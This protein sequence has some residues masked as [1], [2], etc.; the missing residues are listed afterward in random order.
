MNNIKLLHIKCC[1]FQFFNSPVALKNQ[2]KFWP[3]KKKLKWRPCHI[4][5]GRHPIISTLMLHMP[6]P[7]QS[8]SPHHAPRLLSQ[9]QKT[10]NPHWA[11]YPSATLR[12]SISPSSILSSP[13]FADSLPS[14][15]RFQS[16]M[17]THSGHK[18]C[19]SFPLCSMNPSLWPSGIG[20]RFRRNRLWVRFLAVSDI[21]PMFIEPTITWVPSGFLGTYGLTQ[22]LC[23]K[24][25]IMHPELSG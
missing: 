3:P 18:P 11:S 10:T 14:S 4:P 21:Y 13:D 2:K 5:T 7:P 9:P 24:K 17:P 1:F 6:K 16:H 25:K 23:L 19:K 8:T 15:P 20:S 12:T 22:K